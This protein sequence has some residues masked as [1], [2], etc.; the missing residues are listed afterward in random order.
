M[1]RTSNGGGTQNGRFV[2]T[3]ETINI[4]NESNWTDGGVA[5]PNPFTTRQ[6]DMVFEKHI[7]RR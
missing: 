3:G 4:A 1:E 7:C 6:V 5:S 2:H